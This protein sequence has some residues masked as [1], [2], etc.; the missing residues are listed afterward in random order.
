MTFRVK[1]SAISVETIDKLRAAGLDVTHGWAGYADRVADVPV[2]A[3]TTVTAPDEDGARAVIASALGLDAG[4]LSA[5]VE[6]ER[7]DD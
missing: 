5:A 7:V 2:G 4:D 3:E 1:L 6:F